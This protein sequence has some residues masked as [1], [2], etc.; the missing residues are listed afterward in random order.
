M[1]APK[2]ERHPTCVATHC[3]GKNAES[4]PCWAA[5]PLPVVEPDERPSARLLAAIQRFRDGVDLTRFGCVYVLPEDAV[6][7]ADALDRL[8]L[9]IR[10]DG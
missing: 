8:A 4:V 2:W 6:I 10:A 1:S 9:N 5:L 7:L 3:C